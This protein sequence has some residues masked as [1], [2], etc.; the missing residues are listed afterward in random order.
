MKS[1][2]VITYL[3]GCAACLVVGWV[4]RTL[5]GYKHRLDELDEKH[6]DKRV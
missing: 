1:N 2:I 5:W 6:I 3:I 4:L